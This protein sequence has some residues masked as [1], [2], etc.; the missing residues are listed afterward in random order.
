MARAHNVY[1]V[2]GSGT[3]IEPLA[4]FTVKYELVTW[5]ENRSQHQPLRAPVAIYRMGDNRKAC[6]LL[7]EKDLL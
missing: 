7:F 1:V 2:M 3:R 4:A 5:L 6:E